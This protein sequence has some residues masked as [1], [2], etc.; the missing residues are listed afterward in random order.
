MALFPTA[1]AAARTRSTPHRFAVAVTLVALAAGGAPAAMAATHHR[2]AAK[3]HSAR[4]KSHRK[5]TKKHRNATVSRRSSTTTTPVVSVSGQT[6][7]WKAVSG[8][9]SY[10]LATTVSGSANTYRV[11]TGTS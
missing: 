10:V 4:H 9:S 3:H 2:S 5:A 8:V 11:V 6:V 1:C 7:S